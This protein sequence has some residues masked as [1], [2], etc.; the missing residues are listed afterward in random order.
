M[1]ARLVRRAQQAGAKLT[2][3]QSNSESA[4]V[5][6]IQQARREGVDFIIINP[7]A[8]T[9]TS[10][11][12]RD[13]LAAVGIPFIEVHLSNVS[14]ARVIPA[15]S[16]ISATSRRASSA[17]W[18]PRATS[19]PW[20]LRCNTPGSEN[21]DDGSAQAEVADRPRP[22]VGNR[23]ARNHRGRG[24]GSH[25]PRQ[26]WR[27]RT[28]R[29][30]RCT[31]SR[32]RRRRPLPPPRLPPPRRPSR[33]PPEPEGHV[34]RSPMVGTFYRSAAPGAKA[35]VQ[36]GDTVKAGRDPVHHRGDEAPERDRVRPRRD[37]EGDTRRERPA[38]GVRRAARD[39]FLNGVS[40]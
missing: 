12:M 40:R 6:R 21:G 3:F 1:M 35:F 20:N 14:R 27:R 9:H 10:V 25:L 31:P 24:K 4:L 22:A 32:P 33:K 29:P 26:P 7:A 17:G 13:A 37:G 19:L 8:Y 39:S 23:R 2:T 16:R 36:V 38:G 28:P 15:R 30:R 11:A 18:A 34:I 5:D